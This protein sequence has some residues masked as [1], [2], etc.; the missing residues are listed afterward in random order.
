MLKLVINYDMMDKIYEAKGEN[1]LKLVYKKYSKM[2]IIMY[3]IIAGTIFDLGNIYKGVEVSF[4]TFHVALEIGLFF[5]GIPAIH[6]GLEKL[7]VSKFGKK[8]FQQTATDEIKNLSIQLNNQNIKTTPEL[9]LDS[10]VYHKKYKLAMEGIPGIIRE[11]YIN[12]PTYGFNNNIE[13]TSILEEHRIGSKD[14]ILTLGTPKK[15]KI[16]SYKKAYGM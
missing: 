14:Y 9:L 10:A 4:S 7:D 11:R 2:P 3:P 1:K 8:S 6:F 13:E 15:K 16:L 12:V 5:V